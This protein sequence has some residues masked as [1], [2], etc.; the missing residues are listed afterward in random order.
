MRTAANFSYGHASLCLKA[1]GT[2]AAE[3]SSL[4]WTEVHTRLKIEPARCFSPHLFN[5]NA[6]FCC[7]YYK[8]FRFT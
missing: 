7:G 3:V 6:L 1:T 4:D 2:F 5:I 8:L